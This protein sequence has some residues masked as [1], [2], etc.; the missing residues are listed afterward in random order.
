M[1]RFSGGAS[2]ISNSGPV[3]LCDGG[4]DSRKRLL[5]D[6]IRLECG[7]WT[8]FVAQVG[9]IVLPDDSRDLE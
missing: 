5:I 4:F 1:L 2:R 7:Q 9:S 8:R 3:T 6:T